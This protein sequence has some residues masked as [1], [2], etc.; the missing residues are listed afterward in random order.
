MGETSF[1]AVAAA[2]L[3]LAAG[4]LLGASAWRA[5]QRRRLA[6][7]AL[8]SGRR[9]R[10]FLLV[11]RG[12]EPLKP[13]SRRLMGVRVVAEAT[14]G[15]A[16]YLAERGYAGDAAAI[17]SSALA[18]TLCLALACGVLSSSVVCGIAVGCC[19]LGA[20]VALER[21]ASDR[22]H[23]LM[24]EEVPEALRC[25]EVCFR[26]G[27]SLMQTL[28]Q[29]SREVKGPLGKLFE[30]AARRIEMGAPASEALGALHGGKRVPELAFVAVA[31]DVQHQSG[32]SVA[33]VLEAAR[34][35]VEGELDLMR[36][37]RVQTAQAKLS[38]RIVTLM[39]FV[40]V[41]LF[42]LV[43][44]DFLMPFFSSLGG[45]ALLALALAMQLAG[46]LTVRRML[47][48]EAG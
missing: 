31:L 23:A 6:A 13:L 40:L 36:A 5:F 35:S 28:Q 32:G 29:T 46:V 41:A 2:L 4:L 37:L 10:T 47:K 38:A 48:V 22:H 12:F 1:W 39:P 45:V 18:A 7:S 33:P 42:S 19:A 3:A 27:L 30:A 24:R 26:S 8:A 44:P 15:A 25:M 20:M 34:E 14:C 11:A 16:T 43:S 17:L 21:S 9:E